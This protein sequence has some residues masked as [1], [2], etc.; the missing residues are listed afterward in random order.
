MWDW[1]TYSQLNF[2][3]TVVCSL[4]L[5]YL[6]RAQAHSFLIRCTRLLYS[7]LRL[8]SRA[9]LRTAQRIRLR[10]HEVIKALAEALVERQLERRFMR[11]ERVVERDLAS[12]QLLA[13]EINRQLTKVDE[14]YAESAKLPDLMPQWVE[15]VESIAQLEVNGG[16][17]DVMAKILDEMHATIQRHQREA[18]REHRWTVAS[19]HKILAGIQPRWRKMTRLLQQ[20]ESNIEMLRHRLHRVDQQM[21]HFEMLTA[22]SGQGIMASM[23]MRFVTSLC[24]VLVGCVAA[25]INWQLLHQPMQAVVASQH[26]QGLSL[27]VLAVG[28]HISVTVIAATMMTESLRITH[29]FPLATAMTKSGR[30]TLLYSGAG[31]LVALMMMEVVLLTGTPLGASLSAEAVG[32]S[33]AVSTGLL[34]VVGLVMPVVIAL[35]L[36][37]FEYLLHTVRPVM[38]SLLLVIC[39]CL[40]MVCRMFASL[41]LHV[42]RLA[43]P[44]YDLIIFIPLR[45]ER[46]WQL[47]Q[48][49]KAEASGSLRKEAAAA[50]ATTELDA[51]NVTELKFGSKAKKT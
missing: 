50:K 40:A 36:I 42:G 20:I 47:Y 22:S 26:L 51:I 1:N 19:R 43:I 8:A 25:F 41:I 14:D 18:L 9:F 32:A 44:V 30:Q 24:F 46:E 5:L 37:P 4:L 45:L 6:I 15:A 12:Y 23:L 2:V 7:Q 35:S 28:L 17:Q 11:I 16:N 33:I 13:A 21:G 39:H 27:A 10:N 49:R 34:A 38:G 29:F 3:T 31:L 48:H